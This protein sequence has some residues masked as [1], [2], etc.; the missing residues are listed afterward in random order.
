MISITKWKTIVPIRSRASC[1]VERRIQVKVK[2]IGS[3]T[4]THTVRTQGDIDKSGKKKLLQLKRCSR[5]SLLPLRTLL[6][7]LQRNAREINRTV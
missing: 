3:H 5:Q 1:H 6:L 2:D 4:H 7:L